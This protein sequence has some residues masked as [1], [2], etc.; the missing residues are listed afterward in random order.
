MKPGVSSTCHNTHWACQ[1]WLTYTTK[2]QLPT[3]ASSWAQPCIKTENGGFTREA[4]VKGVGLS[5]WKVVKEATWAHR[6]YSP[7]ASRAG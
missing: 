1:Q 2:Y 3:V 7:R 5:R 4:R 6:R